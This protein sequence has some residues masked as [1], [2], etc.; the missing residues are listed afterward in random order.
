MKRIVTALAA[1]LF[2]P[3]LCRADDA[4]VTYK[5]IAPDTALELAQAALKEC[6]ADGYQVAVIV[7]DRFGAPLIGLRD[8]YAGIGAWDIATGKAWTA[9]NFNRDTSVLIKEGNISPALQR[10]PRVTMAA[11]GVVIEAG[12]SLLGGVGVAGAPGGDKDETCAKA[13]LDAVRDKL[14]F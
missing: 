11:G 12:G 9:V 3:T 10:A 1:L 7:L 5:S 8:R 2:M 6:R 13:G 14:E 4:I